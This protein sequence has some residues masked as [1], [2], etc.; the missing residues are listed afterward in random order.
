MTAAPTAPEATETIAVLD[1]STGDEI[2]TLPA[3]DGAAASAAARAARAAQP[4][5]ARRPAAERAELLKAAAARAR[6]RVDELAELVSRENGRPVDE[7]RAG[8]EAGIGGIEQYAELGPQHRGR[9]LNG[10]RDATDLMV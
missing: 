8:V 7:S 1:P 2:G 3:G 6:A 10:N 4:D 9:S 5:W